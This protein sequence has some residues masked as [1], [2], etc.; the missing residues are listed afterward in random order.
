M[1]DVPDNC[2]LNP[3]TNQSDNDHDGIGD[4]CD[5]DDDNDSVLDAIDNCPLPSN[6]T[7][8]DSDGDGI[9]DACDTPVLFNI[10]TLYDQEKTHKSGSTVPIK[11][12]LCDAI[13]RNLSSPAIVVTAIGIRK[14]SDGAYGPVD[15]SGSANPDYNFRYDSTL[16]GMGGGYIFNLSVKGL[17]TGSYLLGFKAGSDPT[18]Y[19]VQLK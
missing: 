10:C 15:D 5:A 1:P 8:S 16:G 18:I 4:V 12:Q 17:G 2:P 7:Q 19:T 11:L 14:I 6:P 3:N 9:G 13:G